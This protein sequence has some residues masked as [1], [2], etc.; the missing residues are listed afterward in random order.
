[1]SLMGTT[2][3]V[4]GSVTGQRKR[5]RVCSLGLERGRVGRWGSGRRSDESVKVDV[6]QRLRLPERRVE[7]FFREHFCWLHVELSFAVYKID[8]TGLPV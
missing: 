1:M 2:G 5:G 7:D 8:D 4:A 6:G 3:K